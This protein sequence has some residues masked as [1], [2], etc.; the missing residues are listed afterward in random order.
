MMFLVYKNP[1]KSICYPSRMVENL[2]C[3]YPIEVAQVGC[4]LAG[5]ITSL[6]PT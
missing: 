2:S 4:I 6:L 5:T 3:L 1:V